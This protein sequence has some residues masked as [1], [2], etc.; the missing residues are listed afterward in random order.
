MNIQITAPDWTESTAEEGFIANWFV[1]EGD[2][3]T[4]GQVLGELMVE[5]ASVEV[6]APQSGT[7]DKVL[8]ARGDVVTRGAVLAELRPAASG[9]ESIP[10]GEARTEEAQSTQAATPAPAARGFVPAS[11]AARRLAR[12]LGV[13]L[14]RVSPADGM[15]ITEDDVRQAVVTPTTARPEPAA[16]PAGGEPLTGLRKVIADRMLRSMQTTAQ[17]TLT[18]E[19]DADALVAARERLKERPGATYTDLLGWIAVQAIKNHPALN[20]TLD[21]DNI[22]TRHDA[23]HL[24]MAVSVEQGLL[25]PVVKDAGSLEF[26]DFVTR[27]HE[28]IERARQGAS[29]P[30]ELG[31]ST[32]SLTT[33]GAYDI[34]AFTPILNPPEVAI[35]GIGRIRQAVVPRNGQPSIGHVIV[36]SLTF[37]HRAVDGA[38]AAAY[39]Q[40]VKRL[41]ESP[42]TY[43]SLG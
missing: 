4:S 26:A 8:V 32:F 16:A 12:E 21:S 42:A 10:A 30:G 5:K 17:L 24:G 25:V 31:G 37:D 40:E 41:T 38:P 2:S 39:L 7:I 1:H 36:L 23:V 6:A 18:T 13:D 28:R 19:V 34:D 27:A 15:R 3:V 29:A 20:A 43:E 14:A 35:L 11:P 9:A 22:L 33:L